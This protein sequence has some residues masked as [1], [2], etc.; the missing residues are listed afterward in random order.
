M[1]KTD[2]FEIPKNEQNRVTKLRGIC[3]LCADASR[4]HDKSWVI[5]AWACHYM[6]YPEHYSLRAPFWGSKTSPKRVQKRSIPLREPLRARGTVY[7]RRSTC[8]TC[9][10]TIIHSIYIIY[11]TSLGGPG[12]I[13]SGN[14]GV[15]QGL[16]PCFTLKSRAPEGPKTPILGV[17]KGA[18]PLDTPKYPGPGGVPTPILGSFR[19]GT[20]CFTPKTGAGVSGLGSGL[21][22]SL[23]GKTSH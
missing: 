9:V 10:T 22:V 13:P 1:E 6:T 15:F 20:P 2:H 21:V 17:F 4:S 11:S 14:L 23:V 8:V 19:G 12:G 18:G 3:L 16:T 7:Y 5:D